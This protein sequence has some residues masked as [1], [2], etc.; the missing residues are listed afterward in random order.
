MGAMSELHI[1]IMDNLDID[2]D[3]QGRLSE[4]DEQAIDKEWTAIKV[5]YEFKHTQKRN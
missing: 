2:L 1:G 3:E 4:E 5:D